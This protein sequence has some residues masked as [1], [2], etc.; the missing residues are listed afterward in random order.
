MYTNIWVESAYING[1]LPLIF[2]NNFID[3]VK[4]V[5]DCDFTITG[6]LAS[7]APQKNTK[8]IAN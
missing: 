4:E 3:E 8:N 5:Y 2:T 6:G 1:K 7:H